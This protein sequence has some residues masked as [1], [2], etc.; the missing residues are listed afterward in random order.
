METV[1]SKNGDLTKSPVISHAIQLTALALL[2]VWCF[3]I[4]QP[5]VALVVWGTVLA[6]ALYPL[7]QGLTK[8]LRGRNSLSAVII[9][10]LMLAIIIGPAVWLLFSSFSELKELGTTYR[11]GNLSIP[12]P[13][14]K[15]K[16]WPIIGGKAD[17]LWM[18]AS[19][20]LTLLLQEHTDQL[21][22]LLLGLLALLASTSKGILLF[23][24]AIVVS[25]VM[26]AF[27]TPAGAVVK[28]LFIKLAGKH[29]ENMSEVAEL[30]VRNVAKGVLGVAVIQSL[31]AGIGFV[32]VGI[33]FA[34]LWILICLVLAIVQ[35]GIVPVS[36]GVIIYIWGAADTMT[37]TL[38]TIWMLIV[39][40]SDNI[41]KPILLG[42]GAPVP[43]LVVFL[44]AIGGFIFSGFIGLFTGAIVLSFG[45]N[46]S[47]EWLNHSAEGIKK[48]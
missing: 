13:P 43:M 25:G 22:P 28:S 16:T 6:T 45:Y 27:A 39:G 48:E 26:L 15:V 23:T 40:I 34:G 4:I 37:A 21:K 5:F 3:K 18:Q 36:I 2:L 44:G 8:K 47:K 38:F 33:P 24:L 12:P 19:K 41:L 7:H 42:K 11:E 35:I 30:T 14:D 9:T 31:L 20:N 29:G 10:V 46:L 17:E 1:D 32:V